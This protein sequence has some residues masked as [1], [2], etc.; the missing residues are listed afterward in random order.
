[1]A[2]S[3]ADAAL[4]EVRELVRAGKLAEA[5]AIRLEGQHG[6]RA[7]LSIAL[8]ERAH[9]EAVRLA[10]ALLVA[11]WSDPVVLATLVTHGDPREAPDA[12]AAAELA[13]A[14]AYARVGNAPGSMAA[15]E[16]LLGLLVAMGRAQAAADVVMR[17]AEEGVIDGQPFRTLVLLL[18]QEGE[19]QAAL[20]L[21]RA[22]ATLVGGDAE[23]WA[24]VAFLN[25]SLGLDLDEAQEALAAAEAV[26]PRHPFLWLTR[27]QLAIVS[28]D[29]VTADHA[30]ET[31]RLMGVPPI[32]LEVLG[33][34]RPMAR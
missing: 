22:G 30:I 29:E 23:L 13:V 25:V 16:E 9:G 26:D 18:M 34:T 12:S 28:G 2:E 17:A 19:H 32:L 31:A 10:R 14:A 15:W 4:E 11:G 21:A 3:G 1:M 24:S 6:Q 7:G 27:A 5:R 8:A 20:Q 33:S